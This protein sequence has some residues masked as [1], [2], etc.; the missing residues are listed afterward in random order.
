MVAPAETEG[1]LAPWI[2]CSILA[3]FIL[4]LCANVFL[5]ERS[6]LINL[7]PA[8]KSPEI[9]QEDSK[10]ILKSI[11]YNVPVADSGYWLSIDDEYWPYSS[12]ISAPERY[13]MVG[14][15]FPSPVRFSYRQSP[16]PLQTT[17]PYQVARYNPAHPAPGDSIVELD[18]QG[19][20]SSLRITAVTNSQQDSKHSD[21]QAPAGSSLAEQQA[22]PTLFG[23]AKLDMEKF[24]SV[25]ADWYPR[26]IM[27]RQLAWEGQQF[28]KLICVHA[29]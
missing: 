27:D 11:G 23:A 9:L 22:W 16:A 20:L 19:L 29:G 7:L 10:N 1:A 18:E 5:S 12:Q 2:A 26:E 13:R 17:F 25:N 4:L 28:G 21:S 6:Q 15:D 3:G 24:K 14:T 8:G